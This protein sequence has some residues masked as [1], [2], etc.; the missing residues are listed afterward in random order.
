MKKWNHASVLG[1]SNLFLHHFTLHH[2][3]K[4]LNDQT[5]NAMFIYLRLLTAE[6]SPQ[7]RKEREGTQ[8][9]SRSLSITNIPLRHLASFAA[10]R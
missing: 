10:L 6:T 1:N 9:M 7:S 8:S 5:S 4:F 3:T 2:F